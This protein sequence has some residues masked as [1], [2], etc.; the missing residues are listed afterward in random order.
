MIWSVNP[1]STNWP[2]VQHCQA[3]FQALLD[4][5]FSTYKGSIL[6][7]MDCLLYAHTR[8]PWWGVWATVLAWVISLISTDPLLRVT[9]R[10]TVK[11]NSTKIRYF[12]AWVCCP[13]L[14]ST[15]LTPR[16]KLYVWRFFCLHFQHRSSSLAI[17]IDFIPNGDILRTFWYRTRL[18]REFSFQRSTILIHPQAKPSCAH[19]IKELVPRRWLDETVSFSSWDYI[20]NHISVRLL[21]K[22][23]KR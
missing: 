22:I 8:A 18:N 5:N 23:A 10:L 21:P 11:L 3:G 6:A 12:K 2:V 16:H 7:S 1:N 14:S 15:K 20:W 17:N 19:A 13:A 4:S 9:I